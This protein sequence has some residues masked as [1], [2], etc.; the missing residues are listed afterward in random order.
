MPEYLHSLI[1]RHIITL[2]YCILSF[3]RPVHVSE[4]VHPLK[5]IS[6]KNFLLF[7]VIAYHKELPLLVPP[8][9]IIKTN[10]HPIFFHN[11]RHTICIPLHPQLFLL[12]I[13]PCIHMFNRRQIFLD[14][15]CHNKFSVHQPIIQ[16]LLYDGIDSF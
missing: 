16:V 6:Y 3:S 9:I 12:F 1:F 14:H 4:P 11:I 5:C 15:K 13:R 8:L 7:Q 2:F 10:S